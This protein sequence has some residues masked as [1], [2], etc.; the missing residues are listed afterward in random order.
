MDRS[1][2][3]AGV[4]IGNVAAQALERPQQGRVVA[5]FERGAYLSFGTRALV[6]ASDATVTMGPLVIRTTRSH[7]PGLKVGA[8]VALDAEALNIEDA[9]VIN[10]RDAAVWRPPPFP[11]ASRAQLTVALTVVDSLARGQ[12]TGGTSA[13][14]PRLRA[15]LQRARATVLGDTLDGEDWPEALLGLGPGLTPSGDDALV[16]MLIALR[17]LGE[18]VRLEQLANRI[19]NGLDDATTPVSAAHV[20]AAMTGAASEPLHLVSNSLLGGAPDLATLERDLDA[21]L[22]I[23]HSSGSDALAGLLAV[24]RAAVSR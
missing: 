5:A 11:A 21:L 19:E 20:R 8:M 24:L 13:A 22:A 18:H 9:V 10:V 15:M 6:F 7:W 17:A 23:G 16:G 4:V 14:A 2:S 1:S 12:D 3:T